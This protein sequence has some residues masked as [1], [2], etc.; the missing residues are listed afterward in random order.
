MASARFQI[1]LESRRQRLGPELDAQLEGPR[2]PCCGRPILPGVVRVQS[3]GQVG[4]HADVPPVGLTGAP[5]DVDEPL[6]WM[7]HAGALAD[8]APPSAGDATGLWNRLDANGARVLS[9][10][11]AESD[12]DGSSVPPPLKRSRH[13]LASEDIIRSRLLVRR[14]AIGSLER[15]AK[16]GSVLLRLERSLRSLAPE[17]ILRDSSPG[18]ACHP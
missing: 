1:V 7:R 18:A 9:R 11:M 8:L 4:G 5:D 17:D 2:P 16:D 6:G 3:R 12:A 14:E 15:L 10:R 13:S